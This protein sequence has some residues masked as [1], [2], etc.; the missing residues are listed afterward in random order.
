MAARQALVKW[1][2]GLRF[3]G[4]AYSNHSVVM[5]AA[6]EVG[7][8]DAGLRPGE[9]V[10]LALAGCTGMDVVSLL[11]KMRVAF[12][13]FEIAIDAEMAE[14]YPKRFTKITVTYRVRGRDIPEDKLQRAIDLSRET[15]CSVSAQLRPGT[16]LIYRYEILPPA[17][18]T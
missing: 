13:A 10:L 9:M 4:K 18:S 17:S 3:V 6:A 16:E 12:E 11:K 1:V 5:D 14:N 2:D 15:Y 7:G 8:G